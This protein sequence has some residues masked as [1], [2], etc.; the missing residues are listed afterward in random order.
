VEAAILTIM[1]GPYELT[2]VVYVLLVIAFAAVMSYMV[3]YNLRIK[4]LQKRMEGDRP[5]HYGTTESIAVATEANHQAHLEHRK[6]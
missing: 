1:F 6:H 3:W 2:R 5:R 4:R